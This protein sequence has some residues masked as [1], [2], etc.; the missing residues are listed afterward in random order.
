MTG[1]RVAATITATALSLFHD[2]DV[3]VMTL[4]WNLGTAAILVGLGGLFTRRLFSWVAPPSPQTASDGAHEA[5]RCFPRQVEPTQHHRALYRERCR[6]ILLFAIAE[7]GYTQMSPRPAVTCFNRTRTLT[8]NLARYERIAP[9]YDLLDLPFERRRYHALRPILFQNLQGRLLD[10]G[11]GT[12]IARSIR[13]RRLSRGS[14]PARPCWNGRAG[15]AQT[16][17]R[18]AGCTGWTSPRSSFRPP[19]STRR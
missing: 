9:F 4:I 5:L 18:A 11:I 1:I 2:L 14:I 15:G 16:C 7:A 8:P 3:I 6:G 10:A 19:R 13:R 12:G 17:R